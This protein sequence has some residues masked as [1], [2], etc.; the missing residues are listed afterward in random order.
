LDVHVNHKPLGK[1]VDLDSIARNTPGFSGADLANL[2]NEAAL[3]A[4]RR[5]ADSIDDADFH[6]AYDKIVLGDPREAKLIGEEKRRVAVHESGH[7]VTARFSADAEALERV[8]IIPRGMA[9]GVT[10]QSPGEDRHV[11]TQPQLES[12]LRVLMGGYAAERLVFGNVSTGA[13]NDLKEATKLASKMVANYGM[14]TILG[15]VY[16]EHEA[17]HPFLGQ[18]IATDGGA[19]DA[20]LSTIESEA[21]AVLTTALASA[22]RLLT[23][24]RDK[25]EALERAL[26]GAETL[27]RAELQA[28]L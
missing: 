27:E 21:R 26:V 20:T 2:V 17:E 6:A 5:G 14:S 25:L 10:Q 19:S 13:E 7:A 28:L 11:M 24:H 12:R 4:T 15:P 16:Y 22:S 8:S 3:N 23:E 18:R 1:N 9:L